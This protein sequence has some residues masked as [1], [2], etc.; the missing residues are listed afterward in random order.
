MMALANIPMLTW[1]FPKNGVN[2]VDNKPV[3]KMREH[4]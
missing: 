2:G 3:R 4:K 1:T